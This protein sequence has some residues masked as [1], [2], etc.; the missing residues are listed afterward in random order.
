MKYVIIG[1]GV[2]G[3]HA[4]E[5]IREVDTRGDITMIG[6]ETAAPYCRPMISLV[7][8]GSVSHDSISIRK[9]SF[10]E[11]IK[12]T[13]VLGTLVTGIDV[14]NR[15]VLTH[16][17]KMLAFDRLLIASGA[18]PRP[19]R[20]GRMD[21]ENIFFM[22]TQAHVRKMSEALPNSR[23]AVV[24]GGGL[25]GFKAAYSLLRRGLRVTML[26]KSGLPLAMQADNHAGKMIFDEMSKH[27]LEVKTGAEVLGFE[28]KRRVESAHLSDGSEIPC[29]IVVIGKGVSPALSFIPRDRIKADLGI[30]VNPNM[31][32]NVPGIFAA[33]DV[34][35][36]IDIARKTP[37]VNAIWPEA[38]TQGR[39]AGMNMAGRSFACKGSLS[40]NIIR[41]FDMDVMTGGI[42]NPP[43]NDPQYETV[44]FS[45][46]R[47]KIYRKLVFRGD[48]LAG[49][50]MVNAVE[51]GGIL[52]SLIQNQ[53]PIGIPK[54]ALAEPSFNY[55]KLLDFYARQ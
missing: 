11:D 35:E 36:H 8:E 22:R 1:N 21:L 18:N 37:W 26:I 29:D 20:A 24:L 50:V 17:K 14:D 2:A 55:K 4:A 27:G 15:Q 16:D 30:M 12:I 34:A 44:T 51:Q 13:P 54:N 40:R 52:I 53:I 25:V 6:D 38:V 32:T 7:L 3:I 5:A 47:H 10:Y 9:T 23:K 33:G 39:V 46:P 43:A 41:I 42:V 49:M 48:I 45:D 19:V 31:E 28:G